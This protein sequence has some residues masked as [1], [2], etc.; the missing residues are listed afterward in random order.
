MEFSQLPFFSLAAL[1]YCRIESLISPDPAAIWLCVS[2]CATRGLVLLRY[3]GRERLPFSFRD[4]LSQ[5]VPIHLKFCR[6]ISPLRTTVMPNFQERTIRPGKRLIC[7][8][9]GTLSESATIPNPSVVPAGMD[10][11]H[12]LRKASA[13]GGLTVRKR[14]LN[15]VQEN[16]ELRNVCGE[17]H[18]VQES[19]ECAIVAGRSECCQA[20]CRSISLRFRKSAAH[21]CCLAA[22]HSVPGF[23]P[24]SRLSWRRGSV[25]NSATRPQE[26]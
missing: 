7:S 20:A 1:D 14:S 3:K 8:D 26:T 12:H 13:V 10:A 19:V 22:D 6:F 9:Y 16:Q 15:V 5:P 24:T 11:A 25:R 18:N 21:R 17:T 2:F 23:A 4:V